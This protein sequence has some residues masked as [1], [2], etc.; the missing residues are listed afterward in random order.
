MMKKIILF[1]PIIFLAFTQCRKDDKTNTGDKFTTVRVYLYSS[2][3]EGV[4]IAVYSD[5]NTWAESTPLFSGLTDT[6]GKIKIPNKTLAGGIGSKGIIYIIAQKGIYTN[7][8]VPYEMAFDETNEIDTIVSVWQDLLNLLMIPAKWNFVSASLN[9]TLTPDSVVNACKK[10][11]YLTFSFGATG[12]G[13]LLCTLNEGT[14]NCYPTKS[15]YQLYGSLQNSTLTNY[16]SDA[17]FSGNLLECHTTDNN[18]FG[19]TPQIA[20]HN[21]TVSLTLL[22]INGALVSTKIENFVS[23]K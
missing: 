13:N 8:Q 2:P 19:N 6:A 18:V 9:G 14:N 7:R 5:K 23:S 3:A 22:I 1:A 4:S 16:V 15:S 10:D 12:G 21:D 17:Q 20:V 11:N